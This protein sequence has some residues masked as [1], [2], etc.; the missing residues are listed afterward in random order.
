V[1]TLQKPK[2]KSVRVNETD[3]SINQTESEIVT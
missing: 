1:L 3:S 2:I